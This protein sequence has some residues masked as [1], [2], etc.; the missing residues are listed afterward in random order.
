ME[1]IRF[2]VGKALGEGRN[3][4]RALQ[5]SFLDAIAAGQIFPGQPVPD[6]LTLAEVLDIGSTTAYRALNGLKA[7]GVLRRTSRGFYVHGDTAAIA[8]AAAE[9]FIQDLV[10]LN[11]SLTE[12][13]DAFQ[14]A[15]SAAEPVLREAKGSPPKSLHSAA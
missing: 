3:A 12:I 9:R 13:E 10:K 6:I 14:T 5:Q 8:Q 1:A 2:R 15:K 4:C 11:I 7:Q